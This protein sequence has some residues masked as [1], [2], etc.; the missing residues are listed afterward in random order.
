MRGSRRYSIFYGLPDDVP[1]YQE[2]LLPGNP[3]ARVT[4]LEACLA[5]EINNQRFIPF[6]ALHEFEAWVFCNAEVLAKHF[7]RADLKVEGRCHR[8]TGEPELINHGE[9]HH[10]ALNAGHGDRVQ[11]NIGRPDPDGQDWHC[12]HP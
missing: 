6:L 2:A 9:G 11:R 3:R 7:D 8:V 1:G 4:G 5:A 12:G 10:P